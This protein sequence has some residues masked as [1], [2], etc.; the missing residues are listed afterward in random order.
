[1]IGSRLRQT[2]A[3]PLALAFTLGL[4]GG[5]YGFHGCPSHGNGGHQGHGPGAA[6]ASTGP[7]AGP[8]PAED[9]GAALALEA[10][11]DRDEDS[12][13]RFCICVGSCHAGAAAAHPG[14][15]SVDLPE[16]AP[17]P[18]AVLGVAWHVPPYEIP[19]Y[20]LPYALGPPTA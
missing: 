15:P 6:D 11:G 10:D 1:M 3:P 16:L 4:L 20:F 8:L 19:A 9:A 12:G 2:L 13:A 7:A 18:G 5:A 14:S 17:G